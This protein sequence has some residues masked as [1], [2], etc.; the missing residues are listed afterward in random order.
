MII[1]DAGYAGLEVF[2][3]N[4]PLRE[5]TKKAVIEKLLQNGS[6]P[7]YPAS[8]I[9]EPSGGEKHGLPPQSEA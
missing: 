2:C 3:T 5:R 4:F 9:Q 6:K 7:A 1:N 8:K